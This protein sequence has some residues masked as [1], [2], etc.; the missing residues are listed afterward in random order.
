MTHKTFKTA[1]IIVFVLAFVWPMTL[2][3]AAKNSKIVQLEPLPTSTPTPTAARW[4]AITAPNGGEVLTVGTTYRITWD[5]SP[6]I[7][8]VTLGY[9]SCPSCLDWIANNIPNTGYYDWTVFVGNTTNTQFTIEIIGYETGVG[10]VT[11]ESDAPFTVLPG[12]IPTST[13][14][15]IPTTR[16]V[17]LTAPNGGEV[18]T[19]G[20]TYRITWDSS[21]NIDKV[22]LGY[23]SCPSCLDWIANNIPNTGYYDW[24]VFV[25]NTT[26]TQFTIEIIAYETGYGSTI[27]YS[28]APFTVLPPQLNAPVLLYPINGKIVASVRPTFDWNDVPEATSYIIQ[29]S[30]SSDF[31]DLL[32][33]SNPSDSTYTSSTKMPRKTLVYWRVRALGQINPSDWTSDYFKMK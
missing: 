10:S 27:D 22:T 18:L 30:T 29:I 13:P 8:K 2:V 12:Q 6:N 32:D 1:S 14:T 5:S 20:T 21:P 15:P 9:K 28:D 4:I 11:D 7:D 31:S 19:V 25:G 26:N 3:Q 23:K 16:W 24:T 33:E 17:T